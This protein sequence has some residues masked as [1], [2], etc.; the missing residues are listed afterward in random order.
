MCQV[1]YLSREADMLEGVQFFSQNRNISS[2]NELIVSEYLTKLWTMLCKMK[3]YHSKNQIL[4]CTRSIYTC[5]QVI[6]FKCQR[7]QILHETWN[8]RV[9]IWNMSDGCFTSITAKGC[10]V[11]THSLIHCFE[12]IPNSKKLQTKTEMWLLKGFKIQFP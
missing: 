11:F 3:E 7:R 6:S 2:S 1:L 5:K 9:Y 10:A 8:Y 4:I 12:T